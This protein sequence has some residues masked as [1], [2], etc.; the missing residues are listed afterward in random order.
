[1]NNA[2]WRIVRSA[3]EVCWMTAGVDWEVGEE[4]EDE[5]ALLAAG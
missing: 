3:A 4:D 1:M 5:V 2:G